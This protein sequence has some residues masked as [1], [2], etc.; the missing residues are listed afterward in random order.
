MD[1][2]AK[3][4]EPIQRGADGVTPSAVGPQTARRRLMLG[5]AAALPS[6]FTLSSGA[7]AAAA[8]SARCLAQDNPSRD[9]PIDFRI[10][11]D[12]S[13]APALTMDRDEWLRK[14]VYYGRSNGGPAYCAMDKQS[15]CIDPNNRA[16][17]AKGSVWI[18]NGERVTVG[19][20]QDT[21]RQISSGPQAYALVYVDERGT[22]ATLDPGTMKQVQPIKETCWTSV[23][24]G[25]TS[26]LG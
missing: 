11:N 24:G 12:T 25:R 16:L 14:Q 4:R 5:A 17:A 13:K 21:I 7:Q 18:V 26:L 2:A 1:D 8:S 20:Q 9:N 15:A 19:Q 10:R 3:V 23:L 22:T 6:V